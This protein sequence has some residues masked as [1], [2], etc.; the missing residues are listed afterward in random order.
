MET[1]TVWF[2]SGMSLETLGSL[3]SGRN[4]G[5][6][7]HSSASRIDDGSMLHPGI[8]IA[9]L[10]DTITLAA[11]GTIA[12]GPGARLTTTGT[13]G[14]SVV[15]VLGNAPLAAPD[16]IGGTGDDTLYGT[17]SDDTLSGG[18]GDNWIDG[19]GGQNT[20]GYHLWQADGP[21]QGAIVDLPAGTATNPWGGTDTL[22]NIQNVVGSQFAD[23][24]TG[25]AIAGTRTFLRGEGGDDALIAGGPDTMITAD[26]RTSG[27]AVV[28]DLGLG[29][30]LDDGWFGGTDTLIDIQAVS[31]S[32][33]GDALFGGAGDDWLSGGG[34]ADDLFGSAGDDTLIG[35]ADDDYLEGDAGADRYTGGSGADRFSLLVGPAE[36]VDSTLAALDIV[37]DFSSAE[38][39]VL[40][41]S[42]FDGMFNGLAG[43]KALLW[44]GT[45][46]PQATLALGLA[47]PG[48]ALSP[49]AYSAAWIP[50]AAG[51]GWLVLDSD[52][53]GLLGADDFVARLDAAA[54][55][56]IDST[57]FIAGTFTGFTEGSAGADPLSGGDGMDFIAGRASTDTLLG[58]GGDD[59]L[60]GGTGDDWLFGGTGDDTYLVDSLADIVFESA[61]A[62]DD[63]VVATASYYLYANIERLTLASG[64]GDIFGV[65]N[66][67]ANLITGNEG[68]N[69]IIALGGDDSV[70]GRAGNDILYGGDGNDSLDGGAGLD[71]LIGGAGNDTLTGG[72]DADVLYGEDGDDSLT[73]G[74][75]YVFDMLVGGAGND[76][77]DG[78][79]G[80]A[81]FDYLYGGTGDDVFHVDSPADLVFEFAGEGHDTVFAD[82]IGAGYYLYQEIENLTLL[83]NTPF[84]VGNALDNTVTGN[85]VGNT[86]FGGEG[87][88]T[89]NGMG[90]NDV[91][92]GEAGADTFVFGRGTGGDVIADF[93]SGLD[94]IRLVGLGFT[95]FGQVQA[96]F[97]VVGA[98]SAINLGQ[99]DF[100][101]LLGV[102]AIAEA[103]V[104]FA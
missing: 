76:T 42:D 32:A 28:V 3:I 98:S 36:W 46:A 65:G 93:V 4:G 80:H 62:G 100:I 21:T 40:Q 95:S 35:G 67:E 104:V 63:A 31:G 89:L 14:R 60:A 20:L 91:L 83:G 57:N 103:D 71:Y 87:N 38:G 75:D 47:L 45:L 12:L 96:A 30:A 82:I 34:G 27:S 81:D 6:E 29:F 84:G 70:F 64:A 49:V 16:S 78:A 73:G 68:A 44:Q 9:R 51:G 61:G 59:T 77:L 54:A 22:V 5:I 58:G 79:S 85:A 74:G 25:L 23:S 66:A 18:Q 56:A 10:G 26:Y 41:I 15:K 11:G 50:D 24:L 52:G 1:V 99:G 88:D 48:Q 92:F 7:L 94:S 8:T 33:Y 86:L 13:S 37:T 97:S 55:L 72:A 53:D 69:L 17:A 39:D 101:V 2:E 43:R 90:G 19:L 102:T